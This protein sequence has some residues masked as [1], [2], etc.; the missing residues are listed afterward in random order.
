MPDRTPVNPI[1]P[2]DSSSTG[3]PGNPGTHS[4]TSTGTVL[5]ETR[6]TEL[7]IDS[8]YSKFKLWFRLLIALLLSSPAL[9]VVLDTPHSLERAE[10]THLHMAQETLSRF[11]TSN[12]WSDLLIPTYNATPQLDTPP[13]GI[14]MTMLGWIQY[15]VAKTEP[16]T[17]LAHARYT[18]AFA[19][20]MTII[21][22]Y[23][24]GMSLG[25]LRVALFAAITMGT[26]F[27]SIQLGRQAIMD[28][29]LMMWSTI[30][31]AAGL[32]AMRP[33]REINW[34]GRQITGWLICG[35]ST[36][37]VVLTLSPFAVFFVVPPILAAIILTPHRT[38][39]NIIGLIFAMLMG[40]LIAGPWFLFIIDRFEG[41]LYE[42]FAPKQFPSELLV[43]SSEH[44]KLLLLGVPWIVWVIGG[45]FQPFM[46]AKDERRR[47]L[48]IAWFW[49]V[50][51]FLFFSIPA[52]QSPRYLLPIVPA[53][54]LMV[55]QLFAWHES[56]ARQRQLD[57]GV[58]RLRVPHWAGMLLASMAL[59]CI[60]IF[61]ERLRAFGDRFEI[62]DLSELHFFMRH[63]GVAAGIGGILV[64]T[65]L[66]G[67]R[68]HFAW[69]PARAFYA[70]AIW[71]IIASTCMTYSYVK[72]GHHQDPNLE[73]YASIR[74]QIE[75]PTDAQIYWLK[76]KSNPRE[77]HPAILFHLG[78]PIKPVYET[79]LKDQIDALEENQSLFVLSRAVPANT[80]TLNKFNFKPV[81][82]RSDFFEPG[83]SN[84]QIRL[85]QWSKPQ[86]TP[87]T[88]PP[89]TT[90]LTKPP[91]TNP[92]P[93]TNPN[94]GNK[95]ENSPD[96]KPDTEPTP[97]SPPAPPNATPSS[98]NTNPPASD[99]SP[100]P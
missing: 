7:Q 43:I 95:T 66:L 53:G 79:R 33:L 90:N 21:A 47:Q 27:L 94:T 18:A 88:T 61:Q 10:L 86:P 81:A 71:M 38:L 35:F 32:W 73:T 4:G 84:T 69:K 31:I 22:T 26:T 89:T 55:G 87:P 45:L 2:R 99:K 49:F 93:G 63:W 34:F 15:D 96:P 9:F 82:N 62:T 76:Q 52:A 25:G 70:T 17:L 12:T 72:S 11:E 48:L 54:A 74:T 6:R 13:M 100:Q 60:V 3:T 24:A 39:G 44:L 64:L 37:A 77:I 40:L 20:L 85:Y 28:N 16:S 97:E 46:R 83:S 91:G 67:I 78:R 80:D 42:V 36:A 98:A 58:D 50:L 5:T 1:A 23:W 59:P 51:I 14:W 19:T 75:E 30:A 29:Y 57:A 65:T 8:S 41:S 56:I 68:W 92:D